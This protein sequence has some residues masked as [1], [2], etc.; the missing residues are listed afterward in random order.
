MSDLESKQAK[1]AIADMIVSLDDVAMTPQRLFAIAAFGFK[2]AAIVAAM[3][4][5]SQFFV[6]S[7]LRRF[8]KTLKIP[9]E[10]HIFVASYYGERLR[11]GDLS[12]S[13][14]ESTLPTGDALNLYVVTW[15]AGHFV[16]QVVNPRIIITPGCKFENYALVSKFPMDAFVFQ[17]W[18]SRSPDPSWPP[19]ETLG[20]YSFRAFCNRW[21]HIQFTAS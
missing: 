15:R 1:P 3:G 17:I 7:E 13:R 11:S 10:I 12:V 21:K 19:P 5:G 9:E 16:L 4:N 6:P 18:P 14:Y 20:D 2:T 8:A